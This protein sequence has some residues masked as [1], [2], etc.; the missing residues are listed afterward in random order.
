MD[1]MP[2]KNTGFRPDMFRRLSRGHH[3]W[4]YLRFLIKSV[5]FFVGLNNISRTHYQEDGDT[6]V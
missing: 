1:T 6:N 5:S 2:E 3:Q 4:L